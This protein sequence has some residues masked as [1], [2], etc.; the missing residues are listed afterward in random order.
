MTAY[1][2]AMEKKEEWKKLFTPFKEYELGEQIIFEKGP[3]YTELI[4]YHSLPELLLEKKMKEASES[5][6]ME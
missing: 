1:N 4:G 6:D 5:T 3:D 2:N